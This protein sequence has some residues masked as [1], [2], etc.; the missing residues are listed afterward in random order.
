M[1]TICKLVT[2]N[3]LADGEVVWLGAHGAWVETIDGALV[4]E[5]AAAVEA[6]EAAAARAVAANEV[7]DVGTIDVTRQGSG[8]VPVRLRERIRA[9]GPTFRTDLGKQAQASR[10]SN[11]A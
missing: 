5:D 3:R 1:K 4:L 2:A 8:V 6:A 11:A 9:A 7:V 10:A